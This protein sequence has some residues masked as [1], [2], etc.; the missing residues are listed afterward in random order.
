MNNLKVGDN[1]TIHCYKHNGFLN[2]VCHNAKVLEINDNFIVLANDKARITEYDN[3][4]YNTKEVAI[5]IFYKHNWFNIIAQLKEHGLFY[6]CN[7]ATPY[8]IE[9]NLLKYIDYDLDLRVF[10]DGSFKVLDRNEY[11]YHKRIMK[12]SK[13]LDRIINNELSNLINLKKAKIDPFNKE[14]IANYYAKYQKMLKKFE[15]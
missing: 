13:N 15:N 6:Y 9:N 7:I 4:S 8:I 11:E 2:Q 14:F 10:P 3:Q 12:Y 5:L 1:L